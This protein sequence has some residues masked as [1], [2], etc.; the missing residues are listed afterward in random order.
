M[1]GALGLIVI[2]LIIWGFYMTYQ[3]LRNFDRID[4][5]RERKERRRQE[6]N[7]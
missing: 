1:K 6:K 4:E 5:R 3:W 2:C 7:R